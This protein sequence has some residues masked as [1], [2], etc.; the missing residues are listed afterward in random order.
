M[1]GERIKSE[2]LF[3][4][5][6]FYNNKRPL[7]YFNGLFLKYFKILLFLNQIQKLLLIQNRNCPNILGFFQLASGFFTYYKIVKV[8]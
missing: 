7:N 5:T 4:S 2:E 1:E 8:F 3:N 6:H